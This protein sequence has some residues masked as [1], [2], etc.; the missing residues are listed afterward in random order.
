MVFASRLPRLLLKRQPCQ[1]ASIGQCAY[2]VRS[3]RTTMYCVI[4]TCCVLSLRIPYYHCVLELGTPYSVRS[5]GWN[6]NAYR[7]RY[8]AGARLLP[9][10]NN[11]YY[12]TTT[13]TTTAM[14]YRVALDATLAAT[15]YSLLHRGIRC[16][17]LRTSALLPTASTIPY[18]VVVGSSVSSL[19]ALCL[20]LLLTANATE[21]R[22]I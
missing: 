12:P 4:G 9:F 1:A 14:E 5:T 13:T 2:R 21:Q 16:H 11:T 3:T 8:L 18:F 7:R 6:G 15:P 20:L 22:C 17:V 10:A 19:H